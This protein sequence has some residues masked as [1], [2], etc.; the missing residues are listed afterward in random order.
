ME[1]KDKIT[2]I[3]FV[4]VS[5]FCTRPMPWW[6]FAS[7]VVSKWFEFRQLMKDDW[8]NPGEDL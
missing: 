7:V 2:F 6:R 4:K 5:W 3:W 8:S 1:N